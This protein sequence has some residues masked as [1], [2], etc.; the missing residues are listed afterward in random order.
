MIINGMW[1]GRY[2]KSLVILL[3]IP[4][5]YRTSA[6]VTLTTSWGLYGVRVHQKARGFITYHQKR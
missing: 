1:H 5:A 3:L 2:F 4:H 6:A